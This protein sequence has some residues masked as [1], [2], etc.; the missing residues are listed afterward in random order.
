M[1]MLKSYAPAVAIQ[2]GTTIRGDL[3][4]DDDGIHYVGGQIIEEIESL[5]F[6]THFSLDELSLAHTVADV[7]NVVV[8]G[9]DS[10]GPKARP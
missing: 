5:G 9:T 3:R 10:P 6:C 8:T 1:R 7:I 4:L 2:E